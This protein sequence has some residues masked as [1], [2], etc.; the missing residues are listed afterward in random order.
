MRRLLLISAPH[1]YSSLASGQVDKLRQIEAQELRESEGVKLVPGAHV[2]RK[3]VRSKPYDEWAGGTKASRPFF[4]LLSLIELFSWQVI[5]PAPIVKTS[6]PHR[7][8]SHW[9]NTCNSP[10]HKDRPGY[11][12]KGAAARNLEP[13]Q[14]YVGPDGIC[15]HRQVRAG[16]GSHG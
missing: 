5:R 2:G 13:P 11:A 10:A 4:T 15:N 1:D 14:F 3:P 16:T 12:L 6:E 8:D 9:C 7:S